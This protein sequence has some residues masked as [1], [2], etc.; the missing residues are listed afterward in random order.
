MIDWTL[1][2]KVRG[3]EILFGTHTGLNNAVITEILASLGYDYLW[4]DTEHAAVDYAE[5]VQMIGNAWNAGTPPVVRLNIGD[6]NHSKRVLEM[7]PAGI[8]FP[9]VD[10][11]E[12]ADESISY[13]L[14]PP[15]GLRGFG[16]QRAVRY[17]IDGE[18]EYLHCA[19]ELL[20]R[21]IQIESPEAVDNLPKMVKNPWIDGFIIGPVDL[22]CRAGTPGDIYGARVTELIRKAADIVLSSGRR[23]GLSLGVVTPEGGRHWLDLGVNM[24]STGNDYSFVLDGARR[25]L[26]LLRAG[27]GR[28]APPKAGSPPPSRS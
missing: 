5:L 4:I 15:E 6:R 9:M 3:N 25:N 22:S 20:C 14:Y 19:N 26:E 10:T 12:Q 27:R 18:M 13:T 7:G 8:I 2:N 23:F 17:G 21:F 11:A 16:P 24:L 1:K 28:N